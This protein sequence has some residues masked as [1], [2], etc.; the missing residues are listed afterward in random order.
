MY[1]N[2]TDFSPSFLIVGRDGIGKTEILKKI[3]SK[4]SGDEYSINLSNHQL[5]FIELSYNEYDID[6][7]YSAKQE[8][9][10]KNN[11]IVIVYSKIDN[12]S[13]DFA[14]GLYD[15]IKEDSKP[16]FFIETFQDKDDDKCS[17]NDEQFERDIDNRVFKC[18]I[19]N[20]KDYLLSIFIYIYFTF[21][22]SIYS[23]A[24]NVSFPK[25]GVRNLVATSEV[26]NRTFILTNKSIKMF[27][28]DPESDANS[29]VN[30]QF[31]SEFTFYHPISLIS[32]YDGTKLIL[33]TAFK[34]YLIDKDHS[35]F[36]PLSSFLPDIHR[37]TPIEL[38]HE[39]MSNEQVIDIQFLPLLSDLLAIS[40]PNTIMIFKIMDNAGNSNE[41]HIEIVGTNNIT[42]FDGEFI[43]M[44]KFR[45][46]F[47]GMQASDLFSIYFLT[48]KGRISSCTLNVPE[49]SF[50]IKKKNIYA[51]Y[52]VKN[53]DRK[54]DKGKNAAK[55]SI[56][57]NIELF[58]NDQK[59]SYPM[60]L[61]YDKQT[62][63]EFNFLNIS[64]NA[65]IKYII[66]G[67]DFIRNE[68]VLYISFLANNSI[69]YTQ[70]FYH[71]HLASKNVLLRD[72]VDNSYPNI[73]DVEGFFRFD[74]NI[75]IKTKESLYVFAFD[76]DELFIHKA[77]ES[78][79]IIGFTNS[80]YSCIIAPGY[81]VNL[82]YYFTRVNPI[83]THGGPFTDLIDEY[84]NFKADQISTFAKFDRNKAIIDGESD[85][86]DKDIKDIK[87]K[88]D[89]N[90]QK[91]L[92]I[93]EKLKKLEQEAREI[94]SQ[95]DE[96]RSIQPE[97]KKKINF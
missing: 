3:C 23:P 26:N 90:V 46:I 14:K 21:Q 89:K 65:K 77:I 75:F 74:E 35:G 38:Y 71:A 97:T 29:F 66:N 93:E 37:I 10:Q 54:D 22:N 47:D 69:E 2:V 8:I 34:L 83:K 7:F 81:I 57:G 94:M 45:P 27:S 9:F 78:K 56:D 12:D 32:N 52:V 43:K 30:F 1:P 13:Y 41:K 95:F 39:E 6:S 87:Q 25:N 53:V 86:I 67:F 70:K 88:Q 80:P 55:K 92:A 31:S 17:R 15:L 85:Q 40:F 82:S 68:I 44:F 18:S 36:D 28:K 76:G 42:L 73:K 4:V 79:D 16:I 96:I 11:I 63:V 20:P 49:I 50:E 51:E 60:V 24:V 64:G 91:A 84:H 62:T 61:N 48:N 19:Q 72:L 33:I 58:I 5:N 59:K